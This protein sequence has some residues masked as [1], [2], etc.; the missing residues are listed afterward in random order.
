MIGKR[1]TSSASGAKCENGREFHE[2][3]SA[4]VY[5]F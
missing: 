3:G 4:Y 2:I 5:L 1:R